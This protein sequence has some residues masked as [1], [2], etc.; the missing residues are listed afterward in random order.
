MSQF[1]NYSNTTQR[2]KDSV[3][4]LN[5]TSEQITDD[6]K[7]FEQQFFI[8]LALASKVKATD[9]AVKLLKNSKTL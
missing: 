2:L 3:N 8:G 7:N 1:V 5:P 9:M 4:Q 6:K